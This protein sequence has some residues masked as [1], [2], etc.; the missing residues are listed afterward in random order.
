MSSSL[1]ITIAAIAAVVWLAYLGVSALRSRG[2][3]EVPANLAPGATDDVLETRRLERVQQGAVLLSAVLAVGLPLYYLG[4]QSRQEGFVEQFEEE[5]L[6]RGEEL[7]AEF[8]CWNCHGPDGVGGAAAFIDARTGVEVS[9]AAPALNDIFFRYGRDEVVYWTA[10]GRGNSPMPAWGLEGGGPMNEAQVED[11]VNY[12]QSIQVDQPE[13]VGVVEATVSGALS[14]LENADATLDGFILQQRQVIQDLQ[15]GPEQLPPL[16]AIAAD[17]AA[18]LEASD[19]GIDTDGDGVSDS[20]EIAI[21]EASQAALEVLRPPGLEAITFDPNDPESTGAPDGD[22]AEQVIANLESLVA[23]GYPIL[24]PNLDEID[25]ALEE[26][27]E[28]ADGDGLTDTAEQTLTTQ[29]SLALESTLPANLEVVELDPTNPES[30]GEPDQVVAR[31]VVAELE[32]IVGNL[33]IEVE[34][35]DSLLQSAEESLDALL[36]KQEAKRWEVDIQGVADSTFDGDLETAERAV[37][38]F[39]G[40]CSRCHTAS[41]SAGAPF[42]LE[43]GSGGFGPALW[44]GRVQVQFESPEDLKEF[45]LVGARLNEP[46]GIN[47]FGNGQMPGFGQTLSSDDLDLIVQYLWEGDLSGMG[48]P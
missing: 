9:W 40:Y 7:V 4:E 20:A 24:Q 27:G 5:S 21:S 37:G 26:T 17:A 15:R 31:R 19:E 13:A 45:L 8:Q 44:D 10:F 39:Y 14:Q 22:T 46:Y 6:H 30:E 47:G 38:L 3:E 1:V 35:Q 36:G 43:P 28:D 41:W 48:E 25:A 12:I 42:A 34:N 23:G 18:A 16:E 33:S 29:L 11:V 2:K 32:T